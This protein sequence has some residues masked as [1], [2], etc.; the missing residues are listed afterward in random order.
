MA[1]TIVAVL[2]KARAFVEGLTHL[3][4]SARGAVPHAQFARDYNTLRHLAMEAAPGLDE[5]LLGEYVGVYKIPAGEFSRARHVEIE[6]YAR[7]IMEQL[8]LLT[9]PVPR[10]G[11][12][13]TLQVP[14]VPPGK[15]YDVAT[16]RK[17]YTQA[18][19]PWSQ[20]DDEH[21]RSRF[22]EGATIKD[23]VS[24]LGRQPGGIRSRLRRLGLE[25]PILGEE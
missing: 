19:A 16:I 7:E 14:I 12:A 25:R 18:Y 10:S 2:G 24:E 9:S 6:V 20:E 17:E 4:R 8:A 23:L 5:R 15:A 3:P 21:L 13:D 1:P 11:G 22:L